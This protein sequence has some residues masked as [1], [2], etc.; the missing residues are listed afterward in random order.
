MIVNHSRFAAICECTA[1]LDSCSLD[2][3]FPI[4]W[5]IYRRQKPMYLLEDLSEFNIEFTCSI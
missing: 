1:R 3:F 5:S 4:N 2:P